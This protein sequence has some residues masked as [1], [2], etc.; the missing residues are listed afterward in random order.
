MNRLYIMITIPPR[1]DKAK[2]QVYSLIENVFLVRGKRG[3]VVEARQA[4]RSR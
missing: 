2:M 1:A 4:F 3:V